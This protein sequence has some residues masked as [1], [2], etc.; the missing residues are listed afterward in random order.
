MKPVRVPS[1]VSDV[2]VDEP[3]TQASPASFSVFVTPTISLLPAGPASARTLAFPASAC[4]PLS[5]SAVPVGAPSIVSSVWSLSFFEW[6][7]LYRATKYLAQA[8]CSRPMSAAGPVTGAMKPSVRLLPHLTSAVATEA[9]DFVLAPLVPVATTATNA[10]AATSRA[11]I[12]FFI[13]FPPSLYPQMRR[14]SASLV[15]L[16]RA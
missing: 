10:S 15:C 5:A 8:T 3:E 7:L 12:D 9:G 14:R 11:N 16:G 4:A 1:V 2:R 6:V 13:Q